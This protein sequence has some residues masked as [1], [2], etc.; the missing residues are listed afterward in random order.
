M[1]VTTLRHL[2]T[3]RIHGLGWLSLR[4]VG[5]ATGWS[6]VDGSVSKILAEAVDHGEVLRSEDGGRVR[7]KAVA[8]PP[9]KRREPRR[10]GRLVDGNG[11][12]ITCEHCDRAAVIQWCG[13]PLCLAHF[14]ADDIHREVEVCRR[15]RSTAREGERVRTL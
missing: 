13:E 7:W 15:A 2:L 8:P 9:Q 4:Q 14:R 12:Y 3:E 11:R 5:G 1:P 10:L 6:N